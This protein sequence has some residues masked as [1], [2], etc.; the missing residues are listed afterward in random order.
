MT[1]H[2]NRRIGTLVN[3]VTALANRELEEVLAFIAL[4]LGLIRP[5]FEDIEDCT[6]P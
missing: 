4:R 3:Y 2:L 6:T 1:E 5:Q